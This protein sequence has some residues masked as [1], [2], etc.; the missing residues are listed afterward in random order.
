MTQNGR[1]GR[2]G[3]CFGCTIAI[4]AG[5]NYDIVDG[6]LLVIRLDFAVV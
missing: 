2:L 3:K 5:R 4:A 1:N 6:R